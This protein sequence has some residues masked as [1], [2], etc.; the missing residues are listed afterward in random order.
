MSTNKWSDSRMIQRI[1]DDVSNRS[2]RAP[3]KQP[4]VMDDAAKQMLMDYTFELTSSIIESCSALAKHRGSETIEPEDV[5][6]ILGKN[7]ESFFF[8]SYNVFSKKVG[9]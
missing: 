9:N 3:S 1:L 4:T 2:D 6:L 7:K 5:N 8:F